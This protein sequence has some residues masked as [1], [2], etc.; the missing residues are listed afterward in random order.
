M[1]L[2]LNK[3][4]KIILSGAYFILALAFL[5][6]RGASNELAYWDTYCSASSQLDSAKCLKQHIYDRTGSMW[7]SSAGENFIFALVS[8]I[9]FW[10]VWIL[11]KKIKIGNVS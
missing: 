6:Y 5:T 11:I 9:I 4:Q 1:E 2:K 7:L 8:L 10:V 3:S